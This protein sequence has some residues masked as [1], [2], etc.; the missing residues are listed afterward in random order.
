MDQSQLGKE[1]DYFYSYFSTLYE[2]YKVQYEESVEGKQLQILNESA[3]GIITEN[4]R[5]IP[6]ELKENINKLV[7]CKKVLKDRFQNVNLMIEVFEHANRNKHTT[8]KLSKYIIRVI[9]ILIFLCNKIHP[10]HE[11]HT[12]N[13][14]IVCSPLKKRLSKK[15]QGECDKGIATYNINSGMT[16]TLMNTGV[17]A[18]IVFRQEEVIKVIIHELI[19]AFGLDSKLMAPET[20]APLNAFFGLRMSEQQKLQANES[21]TDSYACLLNVFL[22]TKFLC[23]GVVESMTEKCVFRGLI[24]RELVYIVGRAIKLFPFLGL[25]IDERTSK[26]VNKCNTRSEQTHVISYYI[27]KAMNFLNLIVFLKYLRNN[28]YKSKEDGIVYVQHLLK[29]LKMK[30]GNQSIPTI[31]ITNC[32]FTITIHKK[33]IKFLKRL[34]KIEH[35]EWSLRM[36]CIDV[37]AI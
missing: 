29:L 28:D 37:S 5:Y 11:V 3:T 14:K 30:W 16:T 21:F 24:S 31:D 9:Y 25:E 35:D 12:L 20:E 15:P 8:I 32:Q 19:H 17:V 2:Y 6:V 23:G 1:L 33:I 22:A 36:S 26:L 4:S 13:I 18:I 7:F 27:L 10:L 34:L